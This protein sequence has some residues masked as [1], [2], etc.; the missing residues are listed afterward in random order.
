M[1]LRSLNGKIIGVVNNHMT[2]PNYG[3][4]LVKEVVVRKASE[5]LRMVKLDESILDMKFSDLSSR[6][7]SKIILASRLLDDVIVVEGFSKGLIKQ[8]IEYFKK[9]FKKI[10]E[11][12]RKMVIVDNNMEMFIDCVDNMYVIKDDLIMYNTNDL[13]DAQL[14]LYC[15]VPKIVKFTMQSSKLG[16]RIQHYK[17]LDELLKAIYR[18]KS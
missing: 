1:E 4:R 9:L 14:E 11:Y 17:E 15:D 6:N 10:S 12:D 7:K 8:D 16:V 5:S 3:D 18:I 2:I 13:Y